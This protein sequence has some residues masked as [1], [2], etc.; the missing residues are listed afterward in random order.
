MFSPKVIVSPSHQDAKSETVSSPTSHYFSTNHYAQQLNLDAIRQNSTQDALRLASQ[1]NVKHDANG[2][3]GCDAVAGYYV[4]ALRYVRQSEPV[5]CDGDLLELVW[6]MT[7]L[8]LAHRETSKIQYLSWFDMTSTD[9]WKFAKQLKEESYECDLHIPINGFYKRGSI[10]SSHSDSSNSSE[11]G[12]EEENYRRAIRITIYNCRALIYEQS[13][14][15]NQAIIY[16]RKCAAVRP[17][18]FE[19]QHTQQSALAAMHRLV[20]SSSIPPVLK[21]RTS[22]SSAFMSCESNASSTTVS[23]ASSASSVK[24][25]ISCSHCGIEKLAMPVC[26]KCKI[27][28]YCSVRCMKSHQFI[29]T[30]VC[31]SPK[32]P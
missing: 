8:V 5:K 20:Q 10:D 21:Q 12:N 3:C 15:V 27:Q 30:S 16:Y 1:E 11:T 25:N 22:Y 32:S 6:R 24:S 23:S 7:N 29:H 26:A 14:Q 18:P 19:P 28:P 9:L 17:T 4:T 2:C 31:G 13:N